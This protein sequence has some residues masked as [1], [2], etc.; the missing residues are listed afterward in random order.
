MECIVWPLTAAL[1]ARPEPA[2]EVA[3]SALVEA[4]AVVTAVDAA[5][6]L[7]MEADASAVVSVVDA[8]VVVTVL[9]AE[10]VSAAAVVT[11]IVV[12][13]LAALAAA[14]ATAEVAS[15][16]A[17]SV[18]ATVLEAVRV[19]RP[20]AGAG[21]VGGGSVGPT[22]TEFCEELVTRPASSAVPGRV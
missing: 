15:V 22:G 13:A 19:L 14:V 6:E 12:S 16:L 21:E 8:V 3:D 11:E 5:A 2:A 7:V 4:S 18:E 10:A 20:G 9:D 17:A 1:T